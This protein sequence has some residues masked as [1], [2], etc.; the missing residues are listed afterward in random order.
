[1]G[2]FRCWVTQKDNP[3]M[4]QAEVRAANERLAPLNSDTVDKINADHY[5]DNPQKASWEKG[6]K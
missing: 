3:K 4:T 1:M 6:D 2:E 5:L